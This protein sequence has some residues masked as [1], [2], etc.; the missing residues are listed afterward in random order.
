MSGRGG[1]RATGPA[2]AEPPGG[3]AEVDPAGRSH[4]S[5]R[6][7]HP[8]AAQPGTT[9]RRRQPPGCYGRRACSA[10]IGNGEPLKAE[11]FLFLIDPE[12]EKVTLGWKE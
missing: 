12:T 7:W 3:L 5:R 2:H 11:S 8:G 10:R 6:D 4:V 1:R 9:G